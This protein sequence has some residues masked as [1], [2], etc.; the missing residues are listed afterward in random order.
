MQ[1]RIA[2]GPVTGLPIRFG[3]IWLIAARAPRACS[4]W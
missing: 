4:G 1:R 2:S 3:D